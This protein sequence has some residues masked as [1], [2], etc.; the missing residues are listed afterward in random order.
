M[1]T[2][3]STTKHVNHFSNDLTTNDGVRIC[4][5]VYID[6]TTAQRKEILNKVR[7]IAYEPAAVSIPPTQSGIQVENYSNRENEIVMKLGMDL[8]NLRN[9]LFQRGGLSVDLVLKLQGITGLVFV[10]QKTFAA[11]FK[12]KQAAIKSFMEEHDVDPSA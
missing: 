12:Q 5:P 8:A 7:E 2:T 4:T 9:A 11:A 10:D 3:L 1:T 6:L